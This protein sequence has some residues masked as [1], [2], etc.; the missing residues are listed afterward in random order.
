MRGSEGSAS[1]AMLGVEVGGGLAI[2]GVFVAMFGVVQSIYFW[3]GSEVAKSRS[4]RDGNLLGRWLNAS[5]THS[6]E[7]HLNSILGS[8]LLLFFATGLD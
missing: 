8:Y 2:V 1:A 6:L 3:P 7:F 4:A 5:V